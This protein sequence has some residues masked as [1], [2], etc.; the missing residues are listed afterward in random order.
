MKLFAHGTQDLADAEFAF[1][2]AGQPRFSALVIMT[3]HTRPCSRCK[4][5]VATT[6][7]GR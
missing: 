6:S 7:A 4:S 1:L 3:T 2:A 5:F